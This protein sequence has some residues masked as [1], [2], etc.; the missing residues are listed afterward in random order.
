MNFLKKQNKK[1]YKNPDETNN[2]QV[3]ITLS[4]CVIIQII[5]LK[6]EKV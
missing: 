2:Q 1:K 5:R 3:I 4:L 6:S